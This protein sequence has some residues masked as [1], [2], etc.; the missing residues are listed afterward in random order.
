[1]YLTPLWRVDYIWMTYK[2]WISWTDGAIS[3]IE[4][5]P[6]YDISLQNFKHV[7]FR[8]HSVWRV[9]FQTKWPR[10]LN[11]NMLKIFMSVIVFLHIKS[12][13]T[14]IT[15][16]TTSL[17]QIL[18]FSSY[19]I[20]VCTNYW[21]KHSVFDLIKYYSAAQGLYLDTIYP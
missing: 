19:S 9:K 7:L 8:K 1:M 20:D 6:Q 18:I 15:L 5:V 4:V 17:S 2:Y 14:I 11:K 16:L 10:R 13:W 3:T 21:K 12:K